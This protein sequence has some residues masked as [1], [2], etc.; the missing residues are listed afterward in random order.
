MY[1]VL[2]IP[3]G[4][5]ENIKEKYSLTFLKGGLA[6]YKGTILP[7]DLRAYSCDDFSLGR[8]IEDEKNASVMPPKENR[9]ELSIKPHHEAIGDKIK[10]SFT[11]NSPG[12]LLLEEDNL[13]PKTSIII[14][15]LKIAEDLQYGTKI[16]GKLLII[17]DTANIALWKNYLYNFPELHA[18]Y[19]TLLIDYKSMKKLLI[20]PATARLSNKASIKVKQLSTRGTP[21]IDWDFIIADDFHL[22]KNSPQEFLRK[23][24]QSLA[25]LNQ[26]YSK[27]E[28]PYTIFSSSSNYLTP[29]DYIPASQIISPQLSSTKTILPEEFLEFLERN[30]FNIAKVRGKY[31]WGVRKKTQSEAEAKNSMEK[32]LNHLKKIISSSDNCSIK[33]YSEVHKDYSINFYSFPI[34]L[35]SSKEKSYKDAWTDVEKYILKEKGTALKT[36]L[37]KF[38]YRIGFLKKEQI[39]SIVYLLASYYTPVYLRVNNKKLAEEYIE[40]LRKKAISVESLTGVKLE[41][42]K[43]LWTSFKNREIQVIISS[44]LPKALYEET[45]ASS[46]SFNP[47]VVITDIQREDYTNELKLIFKDSLSPTVYIPYTEKSFEK[48][49]VNSFINLNITK[50]FEYSAFSKKT[51][52]IA[53]ISVSKTTPP[54]Y[55]N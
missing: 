37:N 47:R 20:A 10:T 13:E 31:S 50:N 18:Y 32:D 5:V 38:N 55:L 19:R 27:K 25:S 52:K 33:Q 45:E 8:W 34:E 51:E 44:H 23:E 46:K 30:N 3:W 24:L 40:I 42:Q 17:S 4:A 21:S 26:K 36:E 22:L 16:K 14:G 7:K 39:A 12:F 2:D 15:L 54:N 9:N 49:L 43:R 48:E 11:E 29:I 1:H 53:K 35:K 6:L 28:N 41:D